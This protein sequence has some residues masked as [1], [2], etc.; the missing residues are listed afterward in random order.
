V[1]VAK[2]SKASKTAAARRARVEEL[3]REQ[4][5]KERRRVLIAVGAV[6][7]VIVA[8]AILLV[9][10]LAGGGG[11]SGTAA[12]GLNTADQIIPAGVSGDT[13][14]QKMPASVPNPTSIKGVLAWDTKGY[15]APGTA[16]AGTIT[17]DHVTGPV[18][19]AITPPVGGPHNGVWM[20]AGVYT[21]PIPSERA[22]HNMEH[23]AVWITYDPDLPPA[24]VQQLVDFVKKQSMIAEPADQSNPG[25]AN[26]FVD[27]SP[28][29]D[30]RLPSPI[31]ISSWGY[32]LRVDSP[33]DPRL[34]EFV[35]TFRH[36]PKYTP[37][38][39]PEVDGVPVQTGGRAAG[40]GSKFPNP[41]GVL[42]Q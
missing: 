37:E 30:N 15:P 28:W 12:N 34:Q 21:K 11:S 2:T 24:Q 36:N 42:P 27:L 10:A 14:T 31:V 9:V 26:R 20:N 25:Q 23:G 32:Q 18:K 6:G 38:Y 8:V 33:G 40:F 35:D 3:Q 4:R 41:A 29:S 17:H 13:T 5:A 7:V 22:V 16:D 39:G 19:Y 1:R